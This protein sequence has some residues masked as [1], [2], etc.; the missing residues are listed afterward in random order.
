MVKVAQ[1]KVV[2]MKSMLIEDMVEAVEQM[3]VKGQVELTVEVVEVKKMI[4]LVMVLMV[5]QV[6][7]ELYGEM[8]V[9]ILTILQMHSV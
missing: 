8:V 7:L 4:L 3:V 2:V 5:E 9:L 1:F 6:V